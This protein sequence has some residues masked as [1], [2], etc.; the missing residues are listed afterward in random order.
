[1]STESAVIQRTTA[2]R[3]QPAWSPG[4][5]RDTC[6][7]IGRVQ[8]ALSSLWSCASRHSWGGLTFP[9]VVAYTPANDVTSFLAPRPS[10]LENGELPLHLGILLLLD[11]EH[12]LS[13]LP[14]GST[15]VP[16]QLVELSQLLRLI[17]LRNQRRGAL[18]FPSL[19][20][21]SQF[22]ML[23]LVLAQH[24]QLLLIEE[25][26]RMLLNGLLRSPSGTLLGLHEPQ[27]LNVFRELHSPCRARG[28]RRGL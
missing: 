8:N 28:F 4:D 25:L 21:H 26:L 20:H 23:P 24:V 11:R 5:T 12:R 18:V 22:L 17:L 2:E 9:E 3:L 13:A 15:P 27:P 6:A 14:T 19:T 10:R 1:M 16:P 7:F